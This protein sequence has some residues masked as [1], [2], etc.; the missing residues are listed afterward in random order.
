MR[1]LYPLDVRVYEVGPDGTLQH[2]NLARFL[3]AASD[4][5]TRAMGWG[6]GWYEQLGTAW[7][8]RGLHMEFV[9]PIHAFET[10]TIHTWLSNIRRVR[11]YREFDVRAGG[12]QRVVARARAD[13]VYVDRATLA[14]TR[15]PPEL[16]AQ[17]PLDPATTCELTV[18][19]GQPLGRP[20]ECGRRVEL[21]EIDGLGHVN[22]AFYIEW[23]EQ[24]WFDACGRLP[25]DVQAISVEFERPARAGNN[26]KIVSQPTST[27]VWR[28]EIRLLD[29]DLLAATCLLLPA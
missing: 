14:P 11:G 8:L 22:N 13:W 19:A 15:L 10:V 17:V 7:V 3:H 21:H 27:G 18:N 26:V 28:Q 25:A 29:D 1:H 4:S 2:A 24:A 23:C 20:F 16:V 6:A 12:D 5:A 9:S